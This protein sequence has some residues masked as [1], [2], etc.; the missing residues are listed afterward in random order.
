MSPTPSNLQLLTSSLN[1]TFSHARQILQRKHS[2]MHNRFDLN[3]P[4]NQ[5]FSA[6][7]SQL[8]T[9]TL[10]LSS[11]LGSQCPKDDTTGENQPKQGNHLQAIAGNPHDSRLSTPQLLQSQTFPRNTH[12]FG[13][14]RS[15]IP[16]N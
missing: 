9:Y 12:P 7:T 6:I 13:C 1:L 10:D 8:A 2:L 15:P 3:F 14:Q 16:Y 11:P 5:D 4:N